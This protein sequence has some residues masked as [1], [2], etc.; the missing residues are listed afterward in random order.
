M[1]SKIVIHILGF[2]SANVKSWEKDMMIYRIYEP[3]E[4]TRDVA[5]MVTITICVFAV[6]SAGR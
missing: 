3:L 5:I 4:T 2:Y 1:N 6:F